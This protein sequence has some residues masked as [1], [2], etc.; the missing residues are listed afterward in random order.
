M[1]TSLIGVYGLEQ[2]PTNI[3]ERVEVVRSGGSALYGSNAIAGTVNVITKDP[4][5][6]T[7]EIGSILSLIGGE[8]V[9]R[10]FTANSS[11]VADDL[12]SGI[13]VYGNYRNRD[14]YDAND[15]GFTEMVKLRNTTF[16]GK[17]FYKPNDR[18]RISFNASAIREY[19][20]G[21]GSA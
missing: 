14:A 20:R 18:S 19:R 11:I 15:D 6:N 7:W 13:T 1:F 10:V 9:D 8:A 4:I 21:G 3:I 2:I 17:A 5:L 16:G 12:M